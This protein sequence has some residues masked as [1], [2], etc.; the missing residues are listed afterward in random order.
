L[1]VSR[2]G[3]PGQMAAEFHVWGCEFTSQRIYYYFDGRL[4]QSLDTTVIPHGPQNI[5][6]VQ[7]AG[8]PGEGGKAQGV[9]KQA[10]IDTLTGQ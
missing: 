2:Y 8:F 7:H 5:R 10:A 6:L 9:F 1:I 3:V 4:V